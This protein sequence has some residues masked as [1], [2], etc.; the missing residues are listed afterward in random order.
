MQSGQVKRGSKMKVQEQLGF[1]WDSTAC[2]GLTPTKEPKKPLFILLLIS[3]AIFM[4]LPSFVFKVVK[5]NELNTVSFII[6]QI[7]LYLVVCF[8]VYSLFR[9]SAVFIKR[10]FK[11]LDSI[12]A[13]PRSELESDAIP[14]TILGILL[15]FLAYLGHSENQI[16]VS[17]TF[18]LFALRAFYASVVS[19][20][21]EL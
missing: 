14:L 18:G 5:L 21:R 17:L 6:I 15:V 1:N 7:S 2:T 16:G 12:E 4:E 20:F 8:V 3:L 10:I 9:Y 13:A 11:K 19:F